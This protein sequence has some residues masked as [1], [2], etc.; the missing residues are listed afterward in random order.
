MMSTQQSSVIS[1]TVVVLPLATSISRN[2][3]SRC[4]RSNVETI[5]GYDDGQCTLATYSVSSGRVTAVREPSTRISH[6]E[7]SAL[8]VPADG[9]RCAVGATSGFAGLATYQICT[10]ASS[11]R[12]ASSVSP[13]GD[14]QKPRVRSSSSAAM[15]SAE[16]HDTVSDDSS[17]DTCATEPCV[18][19]LC[20]TSATCN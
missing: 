7:T 14:H 11:V 10:G 15:K 5:G 12:C 2:R 17:G 6:S 19:E 16:P 3:S 18:A 20:A 13:S 1:R 9:Y 8:S 4:A